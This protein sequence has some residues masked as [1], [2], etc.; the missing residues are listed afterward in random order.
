MVI[1]DGSE[2]FGGVHFVLKPVW[3][4]WEDIAEASGA[5]IMLCRYSYLGNT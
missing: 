1:Q 5:S 4:R 2:D 3:G